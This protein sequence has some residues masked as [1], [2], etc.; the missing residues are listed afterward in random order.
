MTKYEFLQEKVSYAYER[1][2]EAKEKLEEAN[3]MF[4]FWFSVMDVFK[5]RNLTVE[6]CGE[7][8]PEEEV[9]SWERMLEARKAG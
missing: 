6:E 9:R 8:A 1:C 7:E 4:S 2:C 5:G 3:R